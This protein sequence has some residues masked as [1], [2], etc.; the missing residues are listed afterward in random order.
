[1]NDDVISR[2]SSKLLPDSS[3]GCGGPLAGLLVLDELAAS[4]AEALDEALEETL[5]EALE[6]VGFQLPP[7]SSADVGRG[8]GLR[9]VPGGSRG[10]PPLASHPIRPPGI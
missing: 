4:P 6:E 1:M 9:A 8:C 2:S 7:C 5:V 3:P 10:G